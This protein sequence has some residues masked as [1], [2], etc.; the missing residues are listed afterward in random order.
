MPQGAQV[1]DHTIFTCK[2][3]RTCLYLIS[4]HQMAP[5]QTE[6]AD[7]Q[8]Q[9]TTHL[10][11]PKGWK[12]ESAWLADLQRTVYPHK[13]SPVSCRSSAG[14]GKFACQSPTSYHCA[15]LSTSR[16]GSSCSGSSNISDTGIMFKVLSSQHRHC[17]SS[18]GSYDEYRTV[19]RSCCP[20]IIKT[21][22]VSAT[23]PTGCY[24]LHPPSPFMILLLS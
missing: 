14:Q 17:S 16:S 10:S 13:W 22:S 3:H 2:L 24:S 20:T 9:P 6:V 11:T 18:S 8:L 4:V 21:D 23:P 19:P 5:P 15:T 1:R 7:I 12:A